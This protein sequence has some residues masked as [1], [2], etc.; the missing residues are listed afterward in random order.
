[1]HVWSSGFTFSL[2]RLIVKLIISYTING[3]FP[4]L[5]PEANA[6][7]WT[8]AV[9][10]GGMSGRFGGICKQE[11]DKHIHRVLRNGFLLIY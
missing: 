9:T 2:Q 11:K 4:M 7:N 8:G 10:R 6:I 1:M 5:K 3:E